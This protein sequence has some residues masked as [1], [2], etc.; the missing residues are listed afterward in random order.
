LKKLN[1]VF[2]LLLAIVPT[3]SLADS[4][5]EVIPVN[6]RPASEIQP[7]LMPLL[8][9][10]DQ[11]VANGDS[12][13]VKTTPER[14]QTITNLIRKLDNPLNNLLISVIQSKDVTAEHLNAGMG[15]DL[16]LPLS[17]PSYPRSNAGG[18]LNQFQGRVYG[19]ASQINST[20]NNRNTQTI[21]TL[22]GATAHIKVGNTYPITNYQIYP[23]GYGYPGVT[24]ST[25]WVEASTGFAVTPRLVGQQVE[26]DVSPWSDRF[27]GHGQ[28][29][30]Q[31][32]QTT[33][34]V[35]LG[36][37]VDLGGVDESGQSSGNTPFSYN[38]Q[39]S[40][41]NLHILVKVD[42]VN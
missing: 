11:I 15:F 29:Q 12:L 16:N 26:I 39:S 36:E 6:Y 3:L 5:V 20:N 13:I 30:T 2:L 23:G 10:T 9:N 35:N 42:V 21:R 7:L 14:L 34:R 1:Y 25:Q 41:N 22:E 17:N 40:L 32:A 27:T 33:L 28:I 31:E 8:E 19:H 18:Y 37:W 4:V 24:Q 38:R